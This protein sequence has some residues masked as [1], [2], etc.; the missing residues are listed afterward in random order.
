M[1]KKNFAPTLYTLNHALGKTWFIQY[2]DQ[3]GRLQKKY[4]KLNQSP[5]LNERITEANRLIEAIVNP[6][7]IEIKQHTDLVTNL[8][9]VLEYKRASLAHRSYTTYLS[10]LKFFSAWYRPAV[11]QNVEIRPVDHIRKLQVRGLHNHHIRKIKSV[12]GC[13][14]NDLVVRKN[15]H[16]IRLLMFVLRN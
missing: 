4:G 13:L 12:L 3:A 7:T 1:D 10:I 8:S 16:S 11:A 5:S 14:F 2:R 6:V 15:I 9:A